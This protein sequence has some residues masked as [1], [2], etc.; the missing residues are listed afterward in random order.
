MDTLNPHSF[1]SLSH[2]ILEFAKKE[3][4]KADFLRRV[5]ETILEFTD[6]DEIELWLIEG[7]RCSRCR[8]ESKSSEHPMVDSFFLF[9]GHN[10][11]IY[12]KSQ[13]HSTLEKLYFHILN[14]ELKF[15][16]RYFSSN[17]SFRI[18]QCLVPLELT[19][20]SSEGDKKL[21]LT[22]NLPFNSFAV[23]ILSLA[24]QKIGLM[25]LKSLKTDF[26]NEEHT[27]FHEGIAE[28]LSLALAYQ[29]TQLA[30]R[31]R[32]KELTC[33]YGIAQL[34]RKP[35]L[36]LEGIINK[37]IDLIP[38]A[39]QYPD[40]TQ[41]RIVLN[42]AVYQSVNFEQTLWSQSSDIIVNGQKQGFIQV[43]YTKAKP[44]IDEGPFLR[45]ERKLINAIARQIAT[46]A[47]QRIAE[48]E[49]NRLREQLLHADRLATIG[50]LSAGV[51]HELNEP[52]ANILGFAQLLKKDRELPTQASK[53]LDNII[54]ASL[55]ARDVIKKLLIFA[56]QA[57]SQK[58][59]MQLNKIILAGLAFFKRRFEKNS[60][61]L[62]LS[63]EPHLPEMVADPAQMN[64]VLINLV[65]NAIQA[66]PDGGNLIVKTTFVDNSICL[67]VEDSGVGISE[68][69]QKKIFLPFFTTKD[70]TQG[71]GLGLSVVHG[72]VTSHKG[73]ISLQ[74]EVGKGTR[75]EV[76][77]PL[78]EIQE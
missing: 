48:S 58:V 38:P 11:S 73:T 28:T 27:E 33:L 39:W 17:G 22:L 21:N 57:P 47:E 59:N 41:C 14:K 50:Q 66:M 15:D 23:F 49:K 32:V 76:R 75:F 42:N 7:G 3:E 63:L 74:S 40:C 55:Y 35:E 13:E 31:E 60:I 5:S 54:E 34:A 62:D 24:E 26:F 68:E 1:R 65:V 43:V 12:S 45:E 71:T 70:I 20:E 9:H 18:G 6:C 19:I 10:D 44:L 30:L 16:N 56:R 78:T 67:S 51:A 2:S 37:I 69:V 25:A 8:F 29:N 36:S 46:I 72:I 61:E 4:T 52:L 64:Q 77:F 53:D